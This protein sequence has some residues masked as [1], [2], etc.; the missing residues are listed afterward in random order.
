MPKPGMTGLCLKTEVAE[1]LRAKAQESNQSLNEHLTT[2][3]LE[4]SPACSHTTH[5]PPTSFKPAK[6][7]KSNCFHKKGRYRKLCF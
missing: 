2:L 1:L 7:P 4:P 6:Q 3:L 5:Q